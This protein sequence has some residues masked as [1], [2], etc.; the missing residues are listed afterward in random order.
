MK[1]RGLALQA[2]DSGEIF[3]S[4]IKIDHFATSLNQQ[5]RTFFTPTQNRECIMHAQGDL[6][7]LRTE[8]RFQA[9][10]AGTGTIDFHALIKVGPANDGFFYYPNGMDLNFGYME[11]Q[12]LIPIGG[13][14]FNILE[15]F[16]LYIYPGRI[17]KQLRLTE[18][19]V[20]PTNELRKDSLALIFVPASEL[21]ATSRSQHGL[22]DMGVN[23]PTG[24]EIT[25]ESLTGCPLPYEP[26]CAAVAPAKGDSCYYNGVD[27]F[28]GSSPILCSAQQD[29][30]S[31]RSACMASHPDATRFC[32]CVSNSG[33][34][35]LLSMPAKKV[36]EKWILNQTEP[37]SSIGVDS[38]KRKFR[39]PV[40]NF[41]ISNTKTVHTSAAGFLFAIFGFLGYIA[42]KSYS[43]GTGMSRSSRHRHHHFNTVLSLKWFPG[44]SIFTCFLC[45]SLF[46]FPQSAKGHNWILVP[47]RADMGASTTYPFNQRR[48]TDTHVQVSSGQE[49]AMKFATGHGRTHYIVIFS[50]QDEHY[51]FQ[52]NYLDMVRD[53]LAS[54]GANNEQDMH[55]RYHFCA[56]SS[57]SESIYGNEVQP[58]DS[59]Y[60]NHGA[61]PVPTVTSY[62][63]QARSNDIY[64]FYQN[65][66]Y[67]WIVGA[68]QYPNLYH[69]PQDEDIVCLSI[70]LQPNKGNHYIVHW[71][72]NGY[73][74]AI[75]VNV[76]PQ[77]TIIPES[78]IYGVLQA[79]VFDI[80][81]LDHCQFIQPQ[82][83]TS[84]IYNATDTISECLANVQVAA[85]SGVENIRSV[86]LLGI[87]AVPIVNPNSVLSSIRDEVA[88]PT[89]FEYEIS[90]T[91]GINW[92]HGQDVDPSNVADLQRMIRE[93]NIWRFKTCRE[94]YNDRI[95]S[96]WIVFERRVIN[97]AQDQEFQ[98]PQNWARGNSTHPVGG[99]QFT[100]FFDFR[101][102][103]YN[104]VET[105]PPGF[106]VDT[107]KAYPQTGTTPWPGG[108]GRGGVA[109]Y[110]GTV[111]YGWRCQANDQILQSNFEPNI[112]THGATPE[113]TG[114]GLLNW[115]RRNRCGANQPQ[116]WEV[117]LP[118]GVYQITHFSGA[119]GQA[120]IT[121]C[122][123]ENAR[124]HTRRARQNNAAK[125]HTIEVT[126]GKFTISTM[127]GEFGVLINVGSEDGKEAICPD[128]HW[129]RIDYLM[130]AM[131]LAWV[132]VAFPAQ[133]AWSQVTLDDPTAP[134]G[135][136]S[137][138]IPGALDFEL[139]RYPEGR[140][141]TNT[142]LLDC[143]MYWFFQNQRPVCH[144]E[145]LSYYSEI[146]NANQ[147]DLFVDVFSGTAPLGNQGRLTE[148]AT[149]ALTT[150]PFTGRRLYIF[151]SNCV[152]L[153]NRLGG[154]S[155][156]ASF[157]KI[158]L[159]FCTSCPDQEQEV[160]CGIIDS[161]I[162]CQ[163]DRY[164]ENICG[165][166]VDCGGQT[167]QYIRVRARGNN[168][169]LPILDINV[170]RSQ[171]P[172]A[173]E[174]TQAVMSGD[175]EN[176]PRV[177]YGVEARQPTR[178]LPE[179]LIVAD[180]EVKAYQFIYAECPEIPFDNYS[181][182]KELIILF[183]FD[184]V[185]DPIFY[186]TCW[187]L[188]ERVEFLPLP[189]PLN[190]PPPRWEFNGFCLD[191][192]SY[193]DNLPSSA[194]S[195]NVESSRNWFLSED[196]LDCTGELPEWGELQAAAEMPQDTLPPTNEPTSVLPTLRPTTFP[197]PV[198]E[199]PDQSMP[200]TPFPSSP[201]GANC[202]STDLSGATYRCAVSL[203]S[204]F[205]VFWSHDGSR[206]SMQ[207]VGRT[208]GWLGLGI[209]PTSPATM[210]PSDA[211]YAWCS[212]D[213]QAIIANYKLTQTD[214]RGLVNNNIDYTGVSCT[215][216]N[217]V[218]T[219]KFQRFLSDTD[220]PI[221]LTPQNN[222]SSNA[223]EILVLGTTV[224]SFGGGTDNV[225]QLGLAP[226]F[227]PVP[228]ADRCLV[229]DL[230]PNSYSCSIEL[231]SDLTMFWSHDGFGVS[232][233]QTQ[234][235]MV[236]A[237]SDFAVSG[238]FESSD[239]SD[240]YTDLSCTEIGGITNISYIRP[241]V[242]DFNSYNTE[243]ETLF[244]WAVGSEDAI[245]Y[246]TIK[247]SS[248]F[249]FGGR[250]E[251]VIVSTTFSPTVSPT[252][253][254]PFDNSSGS[255]GETDMAPTIGGVVGGFVALVCI[256]LGAYCFLRWY[257][258]KKETEQRVADFNRNF[259][260]NADMKIMHQAGDLVSRMSSSIDRDANSKGSLNDL[261]AGNILSEM[262]SLHNID[263]D[264]TGPLGHSNT[265]GNK[266]QYT[267][268]RSPPPLPAR[269]APALPSRKA[270]VSRAKRSP[271]PLSMRPRP[272]F[273]RVKSQNSDRDFVPVD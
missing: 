92:E 215:E 32:F 150:F 52:N 204:T 119:A 209:S 180:P 230:Q 77:S 149:Q 231:A 141:E 256:V 2:Q 1:Y 190:P 270:P 218:T 214:V 272:P 146:R 45:I 4:C 195:I 83:F 53:Y 105:T 262:G 197:T 212:S 64:T 39:A 111:Q 104:G 41:K 202:F 193:M 172:G 44:M 129:L 167:G 25:F 237:H 174:A 252:I 216:L 95:D 222:C 9:P 96:N 27:R 19:V 264:S 36:S 238:I 62:T 114:A 233:S 144:Y 46:I 191:C 176:I 116:I 205:Q 136:V 186:S 269:K 145:G 20:A 229:F 15:N 128:L 241:L 245:Q 260:K 7:P 69:A 68:M 120:R 82:G 133:E 188:V 151:L 199:I 115:A 228:L 51:A 200:P 138:R 156:T 140:K 17:L 139:G 73:Y 16:E 50:G 221:D 171:I 67:P 99:P 246:H 56:S 170:Y 117:D 91:D 169:F 13:T 110:D 24:M 154:G 153:L 71:I 187:T 57:C 198:I 35:A 31:R 122:I 247:G 242:L 108:V 268:A 147:Y 189:E 158:Y 86:G 219:I 12:G 173:Q 106:I 130:S 254:R 206:I 125:T 134:V 123:F 23:S 66:N 132:P 253:L 74:D 112:V 59:L 208:T 34:P 58:S 164:S 18:N 257:K 185:K 224:I 273:T 55:P 124:V 168:R 113:R 250:T 97:Q 38:L 14:R 159:I 243:D 70:P 160:T 84:G 157:Q 265:A 49:F 148:G 251:N 26:S 33:A 166:Q 60:C 75:D 8:F 213:G 271:P 259:G 102:E 181:Q 177:C 28:S 232:R 236:G 155:L 78:D 261:S 6:K 126:D 244:I 22:R 210:I 103:N 220:N 47:G 201:T 127:T 118:N 225:V 165:L 79:G 255:S 161:A 207:F 258:Q 37:R 135:I 107:G 143:A 249:D 29:I 93:P 65:D 63:A 76:H 227:A 266:R 184:L 182:T 226:T 5:G 11:N 88:L 81:R 21:S 131:P 192:A 72:W 40:R 87:N 267:S 30:D 101:P 178:T 194:R 10:P 240:L 137:I 223:N 3:L 179:Y 43:F 163:Q 54:A 90:E 98:N 239:L 42:H 217:G 61:F 94:G 142:D 263:S 85:G 234:A 235:Q 211:D 248:S 48:T 183:V 203:T 89:S 162:T 109:P 152:Q 196:C 80:N 121:G 100:L 175:G